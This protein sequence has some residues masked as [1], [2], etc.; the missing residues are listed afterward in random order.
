MTGAALTKA[1]CYFIKRVDSHLRCH[2]SKYENFNIVSPS[3]TLGHTITLHHQVPAFWSHSIL[4][5]EKKTSSHVEMYEFIL[6][7]QKKE[8]K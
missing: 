4:K 3:R 5:W 7:K 1:E 6:Q 8:I 2:T